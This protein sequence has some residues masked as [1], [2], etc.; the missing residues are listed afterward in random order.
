M[1]EIED[2][3]RE[4]VVIE[5]SK[6]AARRLVEFGLGLTLSCS[7]N[8]TNQRTPSSTAS[9][10]HSPG[11]LT[12]TRWRRHAYEASD[13]GLLSPELAAGIRR[14]KGVKQ[15]GRDLT[16]S[17]LLEYL[18]FQSALQPGPSGSTINDRNAV[19][20]RALRNEFPD[21]PRQ[22]ARGFHER[23]LRR[24][25]MG[26]ARPRWAITRLRVKESKRSIVPF[27]IDEVA[28]FWSS[29]FAPPV[30]SP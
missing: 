11:I 13:A 8:W 14:S 19:A 15:L 16:E 18:R 21:A 25:P 6:L 29:F 5:N 28:R 24:Q 20:D 26:L 9:V 27:S 4:A 30:T 2:S 12:G 23:Y 22:I 7:L 10:P 17:T 3:P 1:L